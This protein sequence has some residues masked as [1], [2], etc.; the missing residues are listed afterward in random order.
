MA[1]DQSGL[2]LSGVVAGADLSSKMYCFV[3]VNSSGNIVLC[4]DGEAA[5]GILQNDPASGEVCAVRYVGVTPVV[6]GSQ[7]N[8]GAV[9]ASDDQGRGVAASGSDAQLGVL[10]A[11]GATGEEREMVVR[12]V[13]IGITGPTGPTGP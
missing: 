4:G 7:A 13:G 6:L 12:P 3:K 11:G 5:V 9:L 10:L 2:D 1:T 8:A